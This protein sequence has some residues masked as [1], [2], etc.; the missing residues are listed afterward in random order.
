MT[1]QAERI[2][3]AIKNREEKIDM[4]L[5]SKNED[6]KDEIIATEFEINELKS[7]IC[8]KCEGEGT[9]VNHYFA[10]NPYIITPPEIDCP[11][12]HGTGVK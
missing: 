2:L 4:L 6:E 7:E 5:D 10:S 1:K 12:C 8:P 11:S 3:Q 9:I